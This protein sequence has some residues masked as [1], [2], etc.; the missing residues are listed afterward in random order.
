[1]NAAALVRKLRNDCKVLRDGGMSC[2]DCV[3][4]LTYLLFRKKAGLLQSSG[5]PTR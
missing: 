2:G 3:E 1:M 5:T 4:Q